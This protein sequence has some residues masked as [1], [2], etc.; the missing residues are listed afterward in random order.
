MKEA[1]FDE[2]DLNHLLAAVVDHK[3]RVMRMEVNVGGDGEFRKEYVRRL[4]DIEGKILRT[5]D[6]I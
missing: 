2:I 5:L 6:D 3:V 1:L 4:T